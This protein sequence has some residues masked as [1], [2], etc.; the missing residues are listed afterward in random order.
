M[1]ENSKPNAYDEGLIVPHAPQSATCAH[2]DETICTCSS[3]VSQ[4][5]A[6]VFLDKKQRITADPFKDWLFKTLLCLSAPNYYQYERFFPQSFYS[7]SKCDIFLIK[8]KLFLQD[9]SF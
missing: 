9:L 2:S 3:S 6:L 1:F 4:C 7:S 5:A 8:C